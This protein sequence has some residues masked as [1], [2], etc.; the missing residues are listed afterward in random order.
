MSWHTLCVGRT[1]G[2]RVFP[3]APTYWKLNKILACFSLLFKNTWR[4][5]NGSRLEKMWQQGRHFHGTKIDL[6]EPTLKVLPL[7]DKIWGLL[8]KFAFNQNICSFSWLLTISVYYVTF[9]ETEIS[10]WNPT[11]VFSECL[12]ECKREKIDNYKYQS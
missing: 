5:A 4:D 8:T 12:N 7:F 11:A 10:F 3:V 1:S 6:Q 9:L 2:K